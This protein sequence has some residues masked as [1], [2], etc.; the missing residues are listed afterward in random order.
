MS[1]FLFVSRSAEDYSLV[2]QDVVADLGRFTDNDSGTMID[3]ESA[4]DLSPGMD[5]NIGQETGIERGP[6]SEEL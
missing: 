1:F 3:K 2:K 4:S 6:G 5:L